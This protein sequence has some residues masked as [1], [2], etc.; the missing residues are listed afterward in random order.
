MT[1]RIKVVVNTGYANANHE[2]IRELPEGWEEMT[3]EQKDALLQEVAVELLHESCECAA[4]VIDG[5]DDE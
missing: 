3:E 4:W 2:E 1:K 5:E